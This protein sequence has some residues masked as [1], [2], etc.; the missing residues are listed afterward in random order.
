MRMPSNVLPTIGGRFVLLALAVLFISPCEQGSTSLRADNKKPP[1][2][3]H[4]ATPPK[5]AVPKPSTVVPKPPA[6]AREYP[7]VLLA[8]QE[9]HAALVELENAPPV[10]GAYQLAAM[11]AIVAA[12]L[13]LIAGVQGPPGPAQTELLRLRPLPQA[14]DYANIRSA[15]KLIHEAQDEARKAAPMQGHRRM[16]LIKLNASIL[17][18]EV[19]LRFARNHK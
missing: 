5:Q 6:Q 18:L 12:Y 10:F 17:D 4:P 16:A 8:L 19:G 2:K 1:G 13:E 9:L 7:P 14:S 15:L 3:P 11:D